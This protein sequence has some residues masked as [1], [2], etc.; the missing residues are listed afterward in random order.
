MSS[1]TMKYA[2]AAIFLGVLG[3]AGLASAGTV[4]RTVFAEEFGWVS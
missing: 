4:S 3:A 2:L 1:E